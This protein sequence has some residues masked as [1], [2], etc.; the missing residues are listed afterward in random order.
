MG[1]KAGGLENAAPRP[2]APGSPPSAC[3]LWGHPLGRPRAVLSQALPEC[4]PAGSSA[5]NGSALKR[6]FSGGS[7]N[8]KWQPMPSPSEG[9][10]SSGG[11]DQG[12]DAPARDFEGEDSDSPRHS[13]ASNSSNL[14]SPP[15]PVSPRKTKSLS[16]ESTDRGS[17][18]P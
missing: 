12:S 18:D 15:S 9:S 10:L 5:Q 6:E 14:S 3:F 17:W 8:A 4:C 2:L 7:Y 1:A 11:M 16:L 13:T